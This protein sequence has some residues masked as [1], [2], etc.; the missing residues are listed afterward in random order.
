MGDGIMK[1]A[2]V[3]IGGTFGAIVSGITTRVRI[4]REHPS[5]TGWGA[6]NLKTGRS[7]RIK[8]AARLWRLRTI[9]LPAIEK[10]VP[11]GIFLQGIRLAKAHPT[12][13]FPHGLVCWWPCSGAEIM[14]QFLDGVMDRINQGIPYMQRGVQ[15]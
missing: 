3:N 12:A 4:N 9:Y 14:R 5:G 13:Q 2:D 6:T 11:L 15:S 1:K 7:I 10:H 8:T